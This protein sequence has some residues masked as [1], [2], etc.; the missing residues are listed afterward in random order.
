MEQYD[1]FTLRNRGL[2]V[3]LLLLMVIAG[4]IATASSP[5]FWMAILGM[6][7]AASGVMA[8]SIRTGQRFTWERWDQTVSW[9]EGWSVLSGAV[10]AAVPFVE[11]LVRASFGW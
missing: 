9:Y 1:A 11:V 7:L 3:W 4:A 8:N 5:A 2:Q 6:L 10:L